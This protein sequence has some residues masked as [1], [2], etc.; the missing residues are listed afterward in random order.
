MRRPRCV[1]G[2]GLAKMQ[3]AQA[4]RGM[5]ARSHF[6]PGRV[7]AAPGRRGDACRPRRDPRQLHRGDRPGR[8]SPARRQAGCR[9]HA[10][11]GRQDRSDIRR[12]GWSTPA[13]GR[14]H[15]RCSHRCAQVQREG[16]G[17]AGSPNAQAR[18]AGSPSRGAQVPR[19]GRGL[20]ARTRDAIAARPR[21]AGNPPCAPVA[22]CRRAP[23]PISSPMTAGMGGEG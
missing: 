15:C 18:P 4:G 20:R 21:T 2:M 22:A 16:R 23:A 3:C 14:K 6:R 1:H 8:G 17:H 10:R 9:P 19:E 7:D 5:R 12:A 11:A 13:H